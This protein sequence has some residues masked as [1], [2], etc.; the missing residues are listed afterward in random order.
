MVVEEAPSQSLGEVF[1]WGMLYIEKHLMKEWSLEK[2]SLVE[3]LVEEC[4]VED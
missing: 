1:S 3:C 2:C 4:S